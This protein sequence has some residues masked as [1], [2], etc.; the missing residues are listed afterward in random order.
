MARWNRRVIYVD[1][2][3]GPGRYTGGEAGSP[4]LALRQLIDRRD[5]RL[6]AFNGCEFVFV[7]NE[8]DKATCD[9]LEKELVAL[10]GSG[11]PANITVI[12]TN[13]DFQDAAQEMI[14]QTYGRGA[15]IA[16]TFAFIDPFGVKG[17]SMQQIGTLLASP[18][19]EV[20]IYFSFN[21]VQRFATAN[22]IDPHLEELFGTD[23]F[24]GCPPAGN[25][26]A[27]KQFLLGLFTDQLKAV[28][29][30]AYT[31]AFE[32]VHKN[33][34][35]GSFL[36]YGTRNKTGLAAMKDAMWRVDKTGD[37]RFD[38]RSAGQEVLFA[39]GSVPLLQGILTKQFA[40]QSVTIEQITDFVLVETIY[41]K[42]HIKR[43]TLGPL[44][45][46][47]AV[48][49]ARGGSP[50]GSFPDGCQITFA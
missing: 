42:T 8:L 49:V 44:E 36:C 3:A 35:P 34:L 1:G 18:K 45:K 27:R 2:F 4:L 9:S 15:Q 23:A 17:V 19:C 11:W 14:D 24:K 10:E 7:F 21:E 32:M 30:F 20:F 5:F 12:L 46:D 47:G 22:L 25:P 40:G 31:L 13:E 28:G 37:F 29:G 6:G 48:T 41:C 16:P 43:K 38:A 26:A 50:K 39:E 33:G